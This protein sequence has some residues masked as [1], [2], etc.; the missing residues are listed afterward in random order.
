MA[1]ATTRLSDFNIKRKLGEGSY[2]QVSLAI[3]KQDGLEYALKQVNIAKLN[4]KER[5]NALNE[6]R[7]LA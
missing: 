2:S 3:R 6:V 5:E 4:E 1:T 7:F